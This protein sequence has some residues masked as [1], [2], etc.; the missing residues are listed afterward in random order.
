MY[1][2]KGFF[3]CCVENKFLG[4]RVNVGFYKEVVVRILVIGK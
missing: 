2:L 1:I 3:G 4:F